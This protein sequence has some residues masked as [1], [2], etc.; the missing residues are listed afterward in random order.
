MAVDP[1]ST[2]VEGEDYILDNLEATLLAG[3]NMIDF[4]LLIVDDAIV[5]GDKL[6]KLNLVTE[7]E[8]G[9]DN[10]EIL[11]LENDIEFGAESVTRE[12]KVGDGDLSSI[13]PFARYYENARSQMLYRSEMLRS[14]GLGEG[15]INRIVFDVTSESGQ[16]FAN[17]TVNIAHT[18]LQEFSGTFDS[19]L[20][21]EEVFSGTYNS[22]NGLNSIEFDSPFVYDGESNIVIQICFDNGDWTNDET[23]AA[24]DVGYNSTIVYQADGVNGCP[25]VGQNI[26]SS[27]DLPNLLI[28]KDGVYPVYVDVNQKFQSEIKENESIYFSTNDSIYA[29]ITNIT[30]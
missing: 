5:N 20:D 4:D 19:G 24:T 1:S 23:T 21:F 15:E 28:Y 9:V 26:V 16:S 17:F 22:V 29:I 18:S 10:L 25:N 2:A 6:L 3:D 13:A 14:A 11:L 7:A 12:V 30:G 8:T 27:S